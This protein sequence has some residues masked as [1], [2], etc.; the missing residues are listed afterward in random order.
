MAFS[1]T[2]ATLVLTASAAF[3]GVGLA[4]AA[5]VT[6]QWKAEF[7]TQVG[8]QKYTFDLKV[9]GEKLTGTASFERMG[10]TGKVELKQGQLKGDE[11][12]FV[13]PFDFEGTEVPIT[14]KGKVLGDEIKL[15]RTIGDIATEE[16]V[17]KRVKN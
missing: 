5:D 7:D 17:A 15:T 8:P 14:Y 11:L 9:E 1:K 10:Q 4:A 16:L 12:S 3:A 13:E 6:G 2:I